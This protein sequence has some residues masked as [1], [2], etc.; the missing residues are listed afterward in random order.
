LRNHQ[1]FVERLERHAARA[2]D[3]F[4]E[5]A[6]CD[7]A[8]RQ[9]LDGGASRQLG[10]RVLRE[11][12]SCS[13]AV[14]TPLSPSRLC[15]WLASERDPRG[16][17]DFVG[18]AFQIVAGQQVKRERRAAVAFDRVAQAGRKGVDQAAPRR[19]YP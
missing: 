9:R 10:R 17:G 11:R 3:R 5:R 18:H 1:V 19:R 8:Q 14:L 7:Q 15:R 16:P 13:S 12:H 6:R 4:V 2:A